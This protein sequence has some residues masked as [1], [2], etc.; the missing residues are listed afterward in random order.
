MTLPVRRPARALALL[1]TRNRATL[2]P[3]DASV[4][5]DLV[6]EPSLI[7]SASELP[8]SSRTSGGTPT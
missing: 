3:G 7:A 2:T 5:T 4:H 1:G 8:L 6:R